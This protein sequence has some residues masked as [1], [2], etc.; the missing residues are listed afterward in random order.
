MGI[1]YIDISSENVVLIIYYCVSRDE[2]YFQNASSSY[3]MYEMMLTIVK[4][5]KFRFKCKA[6]KVR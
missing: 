2:S 4:K 6:I 5:E 1:C 3:I